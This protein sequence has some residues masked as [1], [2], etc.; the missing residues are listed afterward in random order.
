MVTATRLIDERIAETTRKV[1]SIPTTSN[2]LAMSEDFLNM[3]NV[4]S[5][6]KHKEQSIQGRVVSSNHKDTTIYDQDCPDDDD[7]NGSLL[8]FRNYDLEPIS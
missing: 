8:T 1:G 7:P 3:F 2:Y 5:F 4:N 6:V